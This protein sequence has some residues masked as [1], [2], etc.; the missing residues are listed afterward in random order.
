MCLNHSPFTKVKDKQNNNMDAVGSTQ[1]VQRIRLGAPLKNPNRF[2]HVDV[3][4]MYQVL[5]YS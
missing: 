5:H 1:T 4:T 3:E 2:E